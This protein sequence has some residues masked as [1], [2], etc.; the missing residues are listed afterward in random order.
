M[1]YLGRLPPVREAEYKSFLQ[2]WFGPATC[3]SRRMLNAAPAHAGTGKF[4]QK[5]PVTN[6]HQPAKSC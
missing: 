3:R 1:T 2:D 6:Q 4:G 5:P